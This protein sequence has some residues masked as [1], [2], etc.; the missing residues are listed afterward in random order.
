[1]TR[2]S[3]RLLD[4]DNLRSAFKWIRDEISVCLIP[5]KRTTYIDKNGKVRE[6]KGRAD[7]DERICWA[8]KQEKAKRQGIRLSIE[9]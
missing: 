2:L 1:M 7:D 4:D 8:Y 6:V 5:E 9:F 3:P